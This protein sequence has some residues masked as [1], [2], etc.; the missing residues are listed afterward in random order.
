MCGAQHRDDDG[1]DGDAGS[2]RGGLG[3]FDLTAIDEMDPSLGACQVRSRCS[4]TSFLRKACKI[5]L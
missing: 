1:V 4:S 3:A 5:M 2:A